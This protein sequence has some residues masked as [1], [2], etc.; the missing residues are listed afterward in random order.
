MDYIFDQ[1]RFK[2][3]EVEQTEEQKQG[4]IRNVYKTETVLLFEKVESDHSIGNEIAWAENIDE[5]E[6]L[7]RD[8]T[9]GEKDILIKVKADHAQKAVEDIERWN[10]LEKNKDS[11]QTSAEGDSLVIDK[12]V[13]DIV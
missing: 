10:R 9:S 2:L 3:Y 5:A 11:S 4:V 12:N 1:G 8:I 13:Q 7:A 6:V